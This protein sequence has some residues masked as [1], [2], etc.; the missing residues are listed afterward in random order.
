M[1]VDHCRRYIRMAEQLLNGADVVT[2]FK[3]M[4]GEG[5]TQRMGA[6]PLV[7]AGRVRRL[8]NG[9]LQS[10]LVEMVPTSV[11]RARID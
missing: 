5:V 4:G 2:R 9:A 10:V 7:D 6:D 11:V 3:Q 8:F 1:C